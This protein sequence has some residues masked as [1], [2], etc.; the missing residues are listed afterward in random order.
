MDQRD[1]RL[2]EG[3]TVRQGQTLARRGP[4]PGVQGTRRRPPLTVAVDVV[5]ES[6]ETTEETAEGGSQGLV[7]TTTPTVGLFTR[8]RLKVLPSPLLS[9]SG[10]ILLPS[11]P[12]VRTVDTSFLP[13]VTPETRTR[14]GWDVEPPSS[15]LR[16]TGPR[17][18]TNSPCRKRG[19]NH[20]H[21]AYKNQSRYLQGSRTETSGR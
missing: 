3:L 17:H 16:T 11:H 1:G 14:H 21:R 15:A 9:F 20:R 18:R 5:P 19:Q 10:P 7:D 8:P 4:G 2:L 13:R 12:C 6:A